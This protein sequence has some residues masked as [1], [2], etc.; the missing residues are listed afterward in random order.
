MAIAAWRCL[1]RDLGILESACVATDNMVAKV[2][3]WPM[4]TIAVASSLRSHSSISGLSSAASSDSRTRLFSSK[5]GGPLALV[6]S[7]IISF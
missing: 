2:P 6:W 5:A 4:W 1:G 3:Q 7:V